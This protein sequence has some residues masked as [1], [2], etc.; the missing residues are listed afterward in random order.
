MK[1]VQRRPQRVRQRQILELIRRGTRTGQYA[2]SRT[3][4][5]VLGISR[6][7]VHADLDCLRDDEGAPIE[8]DE[9]AH[10]YYLDDATWDL[11]AMQ[12]SRREVFAFSVAR[13]LLEAFRGT[14]LET[15]MQSVMQKIEESLEGKVTID[16]ASITEHLS[17]LAED[18][19]L[20]DEATWSAL[21]RSLERQQRVEMAYEKFDGTRRTYR[22]DPYHLIAHHG[23][24]YLLAYHHLRR[25][26]AS[27]AVSRVLEVSIQ[28]E[29]YGIPA[30]FDAKDWLRDR[31]GITGGDRVYKVRLRF[32][33]AVAAYIRHRVWHRTQ[34]LV[35]RRDGGVELRKETTGWKSLVRWVLSWQPDVKVLAPKR[36]RERVEEKMR[37]GLGGEESET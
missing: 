16:P 26:V 2:N 34:E 8:Y 5:D 28:D 12:V 17:V 37:E 30:S 10:G 11:P 19:V 9:L 35:E 32:S 21:A 27:F 33:P 7:T 18:H 6:R 20:I 13:R 15:E 14:P 1:K 3:I 29:F 36:L 4:G 23:E 22:L 24:W 25:Q 31:F